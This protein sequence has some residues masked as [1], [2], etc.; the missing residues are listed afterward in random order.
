MVAKIQKTYAKTMHRFGFFM[1]SL[2]GRCN[3]KG[4]RITAN[5]SFQQS[6]NN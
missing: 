3:E 4:A 5:P 2:Y 6:M 1:I